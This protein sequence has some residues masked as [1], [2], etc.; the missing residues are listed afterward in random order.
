MFQLE[1]ETFYRALLET[2]PQPGKLIKNDNKLKK[3]KKMTGK[4]LFK[5]AGQYFTEYF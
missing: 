5:N 4:F 1:K 2:S 3:F